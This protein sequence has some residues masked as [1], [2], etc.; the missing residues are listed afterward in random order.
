MRQN[1]WLWNKRLGVIIIFH[2]KIGRK[3]SW[4]DNDIFYLRKN[5]K[6]LKIWIDFENFSWPYINDIILRQIRWQCVGFSYNSMWN[7][8]E[9]YI[10]E[11]IYHYLFFAQKYKRPENLI[12]PENELGFICRYIYFKIMIIK[13]PYSLNTAEKLST[14]NNI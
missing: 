4:N 13:I 2:I 11:I 10:H 8:L 5:M 9:N 12:W 1:K 3:I 7:V 14:K 6:D